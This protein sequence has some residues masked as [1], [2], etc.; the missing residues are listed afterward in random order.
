MSDSRMAEVPRTEARSSGATATVTRARRK[1]IPPGGEATLSYRYGGYDLVL[2]AEGDSRQAVLRGEAEFALIVEE[3]LIL[4]AYHFGEKSPWSL[5]PFIWHDLPRCEQMPPRETNDRALL[6]IASGSQGSRE[7]RLL[8]NVTLSL[9]FTRALN[10]AVRERAK[11]PHNPY[12]DAR[13]LTALRRRFSSA[14]SMLSRALA[15][16]GGQ[17]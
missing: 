4:L 12:E 1:P 13:A 11:F 9:D 5:A 2:P 17:P 15:H 3:P 14:G 8:R 10:D 16:S 6:S 7:S